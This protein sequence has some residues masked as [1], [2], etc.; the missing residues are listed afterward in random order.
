MGGPMGE[1]R[2]RMTEIVKALSGL[3][4]RQPQGRHMKRLNILA[5]IISGIIGSRQSQLPKIAEKIPDKAKPDSVEKRFIRF[6]K[7]DHVDMETFFMPY[8]TALL[9]RLGLEELVLAIDGSA[10]GR[11]CVTLMVNVVYRGRALLLAYIVVKEKKAIFQKNGILSWCRRFMKL[12]LKITKTSS[13]L[14]MVNLTGLSFRKLLKDLAGNMFAE[15]LS[16]SKSILTM[17]MMM[18]MMKVFGFI[19]WESL[20]RQGPIDLKK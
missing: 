2:T 17:M 13:F 19:S 18:M 5:A 14:A 16:A 1:T 12:S 11:G 4:P 15:P 9:V 8:A 7:N 3:Y 6:L 10:V 20:L